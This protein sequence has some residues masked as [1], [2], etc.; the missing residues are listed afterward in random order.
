MLFGGGNCLQ[1]RDVRVDGRAKSQVVVVA[2]QEPEMTRTLRGSEACKYRARTAH[3]C[4]SSSG[5]VSRRMK[6]DLYLGDIMSI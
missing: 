2:C 3:I 6:D 4:R 5:L 1:R